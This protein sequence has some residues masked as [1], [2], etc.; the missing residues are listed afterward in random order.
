MPA[1]IAIRAAAAAAVACSLLAGPARA[2]TS[3]TVEASFSPNVPGATAA[4]TFTM[5]YAGGELG[6]PSPLRHAVLRFPAGLGLHIPRLRSCSAE[7]LRDRGASGCPVQSRIGGGHALV[8]SLPG[9]Q[10]IVE[11]VPLHAFLG[12]P[13]NLRPTFE[14]IAEGLT[15]IAVSVVLKGTMRPDRPPY[16]EQLAMSIPRIPTIPSE[17]DASIAMFSLTVGTSARRHMRD[18]N[19][20]IVPSRCPPGGFPFAAEFS[21]ADGSSGGATALAPCPR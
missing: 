18:T 2:Q 9:S 3:A 17:P 13:E 11:N 10:P 5:H 6:M 20:V 4:L 19:A 12:P 14:I 1:Q 21:Y 15:P 7:V 16:G 8:E